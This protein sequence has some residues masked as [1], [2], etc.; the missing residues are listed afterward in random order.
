MD[1][2]KYLHFYCSYFKFLIRILSLGTMYLNI[3][4]GVTY[5]GCR[6]QKLPSENRLKY[7]DGSWNMGDPTDINV[8]VYVE[9]L[10][11]C[12][13]LEKLAISDAFNGR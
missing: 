1:Q 13:K 5:S 8:E 6:C 2:S 11:S 4:N 7:L 10:N 12:T 3:G 9:L